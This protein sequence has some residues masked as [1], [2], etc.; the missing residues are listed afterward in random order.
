[1]HQRQLAVYHSAPLDRAAQSLYPACLSFEAD[2]YTAEPLPVK[3]VQRLCIEHVEPEAAVQL[4]PYA[5]CQLDAVDVA[6]PDLGQPMIFQLSQLALYGLL[7][8]GEQQGGQLADQFFA[9][10]CN[11]CAVCFVNRQDNFVQRS[12]AR[13]LRRIIEPRPKLIFVL[14]GG[15]CAPAPA[16]RLRLVGHSCSAAGA[17]LLKRLTAQGIERRCA[18]HQSI[19]YL[20]L[21]IPHIIGR[22]AAFLQVLFRALTVERSVYRLFGGGS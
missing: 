16:K 18:K 4:E 20:S 7:V 2:A 5:F 1:M 10:F 19:L 11:C 15:F 3:K 17:Q 8:L 6:A 22:A 13:Y 21:K 9:V 12:C 14:P